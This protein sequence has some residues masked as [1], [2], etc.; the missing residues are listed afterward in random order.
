MMLPQTLEGLL[1]AS[2]EAGA[3]PVDAEWLDRVRLH[4]CLPP[5]S[6]ALSLLSVR[7]HCGHSWRL[8]GF[9][10]STH[11]CMR[12]DQGHVLP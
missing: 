5:V 8:V 12:Q 7:R 2:E 6:P 11:A 3:P 9:Y 1:G 4:T 10:Y